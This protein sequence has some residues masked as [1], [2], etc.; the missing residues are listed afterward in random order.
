MGGIEAS[1]VSKGDHV[2]WH[3]PFN[4]KETDHIIIAIIIIEL[5]VAEYNISNVLK[6]ACSLSNISRQEK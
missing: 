2:S 6:A 1:N 4:T 5:N 3:W